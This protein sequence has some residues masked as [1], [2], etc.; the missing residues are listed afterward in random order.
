VCGLIGSRIWD[1]SRFEAIRDK[2]QEALGTLTHRGPDAMGL[3]SDKQHG[4]IL[5]HTRLSIFDPSETGNQPM[6]SQT[7]QSQLI[8]NG[9]IYNYLELKK[10]LTAK[11]TLFRGT[12]DTEVLLECLQ[13]YGIPCLEKLRG[14]FAFA[15][16]D[17]REKILLIARDRV[18]KKPLYYCQSKEGFFF[19]SEINTLVALVPSQ[20]LDINPAALNDFLSW[21]YIGGENTIYQGIKCLPPGCFLTLNSKK[22]IQIKPYWKPDWRPESSIKANDLSQKTEEIL[23]EAVDIRL[24]ADVPVGV[25]LSGGIDSGLVTAMAA[26]ASSNPINTFCVGLE[27]SDFDERTPAREIAKLYKTDH[28]EIILKPDVSGLLGKILFSY[29]QPFADPSAIP[30]Y[31]VSEFASQS[32]KVVLNGDGGDELFCG[33]RRHIVAHLLKY[34]SVGIGPFSTSRIAKCLLKFLP[35]PKKHRTRFAFAYRLL[36]ILAAK[37]NQRHLILS[38]DGF[39][40]NEKSFLYKDPGRFLNTQGFMEQ[41]LGSLSSLK[42][43]DLLLAADFESELPY[44][45]LVKMDIATM[46]HGLEARS[47]FLDSKLVEHAMS[48]PSASKTNGIQTKPL[49]RDIASRHLPSSI[50]NLPKRGFEIPIKTWLTGDLKEHCNDLILNSSGIVA[51]IFEKSQIESLLNNENAKTSKHS[52]WAQLVWNFF[53]LSGWDQKRRELINNRKY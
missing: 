25:L 44:D 11:G 49:L 14:M 4:L 19:A 53:V 38:T 2:T 42:N 22:Q 23:Q 3:Q 9:A 37:E 10:D 6:V 32:V 51:E 21:G 18:G 12:S 35:F 7:G 13:E 47:P 8:Y 52:R 17:D 46:S 36:R 40:N 26:K 28:H 34:L 41:K 48:I 5:G 29:G 45:L 33:Y 24:R 30:S 31:F 20:S 50:L 16:W 39:N 15:F 27:N 1:K 43:L